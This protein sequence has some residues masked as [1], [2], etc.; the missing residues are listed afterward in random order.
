MFRKSKILPS[1]STYFSLVSGAEI[2]NGIEHLFFLVP[3]EAI[4]I[5]A[6]LFNRKTTGERHPHRVSRLVKYKHSECGYQVIE[7]AVLWVPEIRVTFT[8]VIPRKTP[9]RKHFTEFFECFRVV[10]WTTHT[11]K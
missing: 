9:F 10:D 6:P 4:I 2:A 3:Y 11:C 7:E 1:L 8:R 5:P